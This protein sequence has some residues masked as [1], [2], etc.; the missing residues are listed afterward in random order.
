MTSTA[1]QQYLENPTANPG[2]ASANSGPPP[3]ALSPSI[4]RTTSS[5]V[6]PVVVM[7]C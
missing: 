2:Y 5:D 7:T 1:I 4:A 6:I 3:G